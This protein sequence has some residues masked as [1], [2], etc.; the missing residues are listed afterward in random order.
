VVHRD[1][2]H[3][4]AGG[5]GSVAAVDGP[6]TRGGLQVRREGATVDEDDDRPQPTVGSCWPVDVQSALTAPRSLGHGEHEGLHVLSGSHPWIQPAGDLGRH[7]VASFTSLAE[8]QLVGAVRR[9]VEWMSLPGTLQV[10]LGAGVE[11]FRK[12]RPMK[13]P[14]EVRHMGHPHDQSYGH[15]W[16]G[17]GPASTECAPRR[18]AH[19]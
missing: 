10:I 17:S 4:A 2:D 5:E 9:P 7:W 18:V 14:A 12:P 8:R 11:V 16:L 6:V 19:G 3:P 13:I 15:R 1:G